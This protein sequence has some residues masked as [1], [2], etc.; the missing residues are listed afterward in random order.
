MN[1]GES[2]G[3]YPKKYE[4][5]PY[6]ERHRIIHLYK[7]Y[8]VIVTSLMQVNQ[9]IGSITESSQTD[10]VYP[11]LVRHDIISQPMRYSNPI[12]SRSRVFIGRYFTSTRNL[13]YIRTAEGNR[14][15]FRASFILRLLG[16]GYDIPDPMASVE[17]STAATIKTSLR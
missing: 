11:L 4:V 13:Q 10:Y 2:N 7:T 12:L 6:L 17:V 15:R 16:Q 1:F 8:V 14:K 3:L 9:E 5:K